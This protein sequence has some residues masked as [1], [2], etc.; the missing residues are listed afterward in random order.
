MEMIDGDGFAHGTYHWNDNYPAK[1]CT[2]KDSSVTAEQ[3][4]ADWD[5]QFHEYAVERA[6]SYV[7]YV[8]D[9]QTIANFSD[10]GDAKSPK[11]W[12]VKFYVIL[13]TAIGGPWPGPANASTKFPA[14][15]VVDYVRVSV[16]DR[17]SSY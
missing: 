11:L 7:A 16:S 15:H 14:Y 5:T 9:G 2:V 13:N 4:V 8:Y 10:T 6:E 3:P 12:P 1:N 17:A